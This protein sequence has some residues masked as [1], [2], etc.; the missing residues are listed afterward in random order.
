MNHSNSNLEQ[1]YASS[2]SFFIML[3]SLMYASMRTRPDIAFAVG[4]LGQFQNAPTKEAWDAMKY[5]FGYLAETTDLGIVYR[6]I[7]I[8][9]VTGWC[10]SSPNESTD[11]D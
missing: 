7:E 8:E 2:S 11:A 3:G 1:P 10:R 4:K 5:A 6:K 9:A